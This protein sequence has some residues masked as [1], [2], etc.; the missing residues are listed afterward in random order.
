MSAHS[1][2]WRQHSKIRKVHRLNAM[3]LAVFIFAHLFNHLLFAAGVERH[4][5]T[6]DALRAVYRLP[7][8]DIALYVLFA[9]QII[10]GLVLARRNW[11]PDSPWAWA[12][13]VSGLA[14]AFF[15]A[16]HLVATVIVRNFFSNIDTDAYWALSVVSEIPLSLYF[17]PY[18]WLGVFSLFVHI[19]SAVHFA[20]SPGISR[21]APVGMVAGAV[22]ATVIVGSMV[23][24]ASST[25]LPEHYQRYLTEFFSL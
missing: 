3:V 6:M 16:Q 10:L 22:V 9:I 18:Y 20:R 8:I 14:F 24:L 5:A 2:D 1:P 12:Q 19:A 23:M 4:I 21:F 11:R 15:L 13:V 7:L 25:D 17:A